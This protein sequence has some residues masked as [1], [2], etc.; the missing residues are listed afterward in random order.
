MAMTASPIISPALGPAR[1]ATFSQRQVKYTGM[2]LQLTDNVYSQNL[3]SIFLGNLRVR[4]RL[5]E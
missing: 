3:V 5:C 1:A 4:A 2:L